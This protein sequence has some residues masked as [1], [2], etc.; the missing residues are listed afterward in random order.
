[1]NCTSNTSQLH[2]TDQVAYQCLHHVPS[3]QLPMTSLPR[4][5]ASTMPLQLKHTQPQQL[6]LAA[7]ILP[8]QQL[9][10]SSDFMPL[11]PQQLLEASIHLTAIVTI[12]SYHQTNY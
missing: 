12:S 11:L 6:V 3:Y 10:A 8:L 4:I 2:C 5:G 9:V 1:M 7:A